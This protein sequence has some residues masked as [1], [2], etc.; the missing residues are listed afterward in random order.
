MTAAEVEAMKIT[1]TT[2]DFPGAVWTQAN[3]ISRGGPLGHW[4]H[5][6]G[7]YADI[8][9][10]H[11]FLLSRGHFTSLDVPN[12]RNTAAY[13]INGR[14]QIVGT[15]EN[16]H[17]LVQGF[18][19]ESGTYIR[20]TSCALG[21]SN[22]TY[23]INDAG[24]IVGSFT[25]LNTYQVHG[26]AHVSGVCWDF[27]GPVGG[28]AAI[29]GI[30]DVGQW[31][32][33][34]EGPESGGDID[35]GYGGQGPAVGPVINAPGA[36]RTVLRGINNAGVICGYADGRAF[37]EAHNTFNMFEFPGAYRTQ[38]HGISNPPSEVAAARV[39]VVGLYTFG[40]LNES[41]GFVA[42]MARLPVVKPQGA[43]RVELDVEVRSTPDV[44]LGGADKAH[45]S[46]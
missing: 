33:Y 37:V 7:T 36:T 44:V 1:F 39:E 32:G 19:L 17:G 20:F 22:S 9:G 43:E 42:T 16:S 26:F 23:G 27:Q 8:S 4:E 46:V 2:V 12:G 3:G 30:N 40:A 25:D 14:G 28:K 24:D 6:V 5:I 15:Y 29:F 41:H 38:A 11:G 10:T 35:Q 13:G 34:T 21:N 18:I 31:V 45:R